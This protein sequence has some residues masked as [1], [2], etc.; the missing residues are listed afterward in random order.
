MIDWIKSTKEERNLLNS[1]FTSIVLWHASSSFKQ[2]SQSNLPFE[3]SFLVLPLVLHKELRDSLPRTHATSLAVWLEANPKARMLISERAKTL[4]PYT[5]EA[6]QFGASYGVIKLVL[7]GVEAN[8]DCKKQI[9]KIINK[10]SDEVRICCKK[11]SFIG[12]WFA[13]TGSPQMIFS[14]MGVKP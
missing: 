6:L 10:S 5:K 11:A 13:Y 4:V 3:L 1:A 8:L 7:G 14:M 2:V 9:T 12:A